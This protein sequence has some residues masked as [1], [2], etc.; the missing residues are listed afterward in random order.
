V[1]PLFVRLALLRRE[2][3]D[4]QVEAVNA[5]LIESLSGRL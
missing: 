1:S 2:L 5:G 3:P 4:E